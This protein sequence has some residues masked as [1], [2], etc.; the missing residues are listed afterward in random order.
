[1]PGFDD[2]HEMTPGAK[3][4][5]RGNGPLVFLANQLRCRH[6]CYGQL[7]WRGNLPDV[8]PLLQCFCSVR[9]LP[10]QLSVCSQLPSECFGWRITSAHMYGH[11]PH[12]EKKKKKS[13]AQLGKTGLFHILFD[14]RHKSLLHVQVPKHQCEAVPYCV[15]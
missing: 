10:K 1:M 15:Q 14:R 5:Q 13:I 9:R 12:L 8:R 4:P 7:R 3:Q 2:T 6:V 11:T